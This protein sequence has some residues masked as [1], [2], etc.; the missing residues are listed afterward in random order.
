MVIIPPKVKGRVRKLVRQKPEAGNIGRP[1][2]AAPV[3][4][5]RGKVTDGDLQ[6]VTRHGPIDKDRAIHRIDA[7]KIKARDVS[8][9]G[10]R[11][12]LARRTVK[13]A[14]PDR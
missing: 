14:E 1:A 9:R 11:P 7:G 6:H 2:P 12:K 4:R 13:T 8:K 3:L 5:L 10:L